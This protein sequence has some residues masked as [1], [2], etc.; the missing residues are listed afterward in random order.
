MNFFL[1]RKGVFSF[2]KFYIVYIN[3]VFFFLYY[4]TVT[5][6]DRELIIILVYLR[7]IPLSLVSIG[8]FFYALLICFI[9]RFHTPLHLLSLNI[10]I[11][12]F[13]CTSLWAIYFIMN[14]FYTDVLWTEKSCLLILYLQTVASGQFSNALCI[15]SLNRLFAIVYQNRVLFRTKKWVAICICIQWI[16]GLLMPLP[17]FASSLAV[18]KKS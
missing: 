10:A 9:R 3:L 16:Y 5:M 11:A 12:L 4:Q 2:L 17:Q 7:V 15:A 6:N 18:N 8:S 1:K 13:L 14:T